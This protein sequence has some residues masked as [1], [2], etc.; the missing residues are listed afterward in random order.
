MAQVSGGRPVV[1]GVSGAPGAGKTT[2]AEALVAALGAGVGRDGPL[3]VAHLPMDGFHLADAQLARLGLAERKGSPETFDVDGYLAVLQ[4]VRSGSGR[5][6]YAPGFERDLEQPIAAAVVVEP[7]VRLVVT[8]GNYLLLDDPAWRGV[9]AAM[10]E[11]WY[12]EL[13]EP[14]RLRRLVERH[15]AFGKAP[16]SARAWALG[17]DQANAATVAATRARADLVVTLG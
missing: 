17:P 12:V 3:P 14:E 13:D 5:P 15:V 6:V 16:E 9:G 10:D 11:V 7:G 8:E 4:R 1:L 2:L